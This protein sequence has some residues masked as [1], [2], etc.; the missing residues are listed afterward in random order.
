MP[1]RSPQ[2]AEFCGF[3]FYPEGSQGIPRS[4]ENQPLVSNSYKADFVAR[5][6]SIAGPAIVIEREIVAGQNWE[7]VTSPDGVCCQVTRYRTHLWGVR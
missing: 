4:V 1:R 2:I 3:S 5:A 7:S 6:S